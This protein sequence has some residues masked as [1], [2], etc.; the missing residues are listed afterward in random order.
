M[1]EGLEG[2]MG[3]RVT[4]WCLNYIYG[5]KLVGVNETDIKLTDAVVVYE[6]GE[7]TGP[8]KSAQKFPTDW[9][10]RTGCIESYGEYVHGS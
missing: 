3:K 2:L 1:K 10:V 5:G 4:I 6:T 7:L 8:Y 9:Y